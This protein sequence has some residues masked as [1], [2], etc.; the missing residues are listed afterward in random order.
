MW[1]IMNYVPP[2]GK[3]R[4]GLMSL[5]ESWGLEVFAPT[6]VKLVSEEGHVKKS[7]KPLLYHY[8]FIRGNEESIKKFAL[9]N[10]GFSFVLD[11]AG[12][13]RYL[14]VSDEALEQFRIIAGYHAGK[15][16]CYPLEGI[17]LQEGDKVQIV[18]GPCVGLTGVYMSRKGGKSGNILIAIDSGLAAVV[19]DVKAEYVRVLEFARDSKRVYDQLDAFAS[20]LR[21]A[22]GG[23]VDPLVMVSAAG[24]FTTRLGIVKLHN[25]KL[26]AKLQI[27]L[28]AAYNILSDRVN[29]RKSLERFRRLENHVTNPK[30][31]AFCDAILRQYHKE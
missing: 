3:S 22:A 28:F 2:S 26:E 7:E 5:V 31:R 19:Y 30:T 17:D 29:A 14:H 12:S 11:R 20:R 24:S 8:I 15:L 25:P 1:Y 6:F 27:L 18:S 21:E 23:E 10:T 16:P 13:S 9:S 4:C